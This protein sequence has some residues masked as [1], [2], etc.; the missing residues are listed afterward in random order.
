MACQTSGPRDWKIGTHIQL[1]PG[2]DLVYVRTL[3]GNPATAGPENLDF[4]KE[5][6]MPS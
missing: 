2:G 5:N 1:V 3:E 6:V 4:L